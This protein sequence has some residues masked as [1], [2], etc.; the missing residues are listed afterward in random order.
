MAN[1]Q[2]DRGQEVHD[3]LV[4]KFSETRRFGDLPSEQKSASGPGIFS[5]KLGERI[6][7]RDIAL[8]ARQ[9]ALMIDLGITLLRSLDIIESRT[10]NLKLK[11]LIFNL[12]VS[13][14]KGQSF[15]TAL[16]A[17]PSYFNAYFI[18]A[19]RAGEASGDLGTTL[20]QLADYLEKEDALRGKVTKA[21]GFPIM[22]L[23]FAA[24]IVIFLLLFVIPTFANVY[25]EA[26]VTLP[27]LTTLVI[28]VSHILR[29]YWIVLLLVIVGIWLVFRRSG[30]TLGIGP[31]I[32]RMK[33]TIPIV[34]DISMKLSVFRFTR[35]IST[36]LQS[37]VPIVATLRLAAVAAGNTILTRQIESA[38]DEIDSGSTVA[39]SLAHKTIFPA[40]VIDMI[41]IGE[42]VGAVG[43][44]CQKIAGFYERDVDEL[45]ANLATIIEPILTLIMGII[46]LIIALSM[47]LPYFNINQVIFK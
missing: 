36:L 9:L 22:T 10:T 39:D 46:V 16:A 45:V 20:G 19:V 33:L 37:G 28:Q 42:E 34:R 47:F 29:Q 32:D 26:G 38:C 6:T 27:I 3:Q 23:F 11:K 1:R 5:R 17:F 8:F 35:I 4:R 43:P 12:G 30:R 2:S 14:E 41:G 40:M 24:L 21:L 31:W 7:K 13:V 18:T 44:V 15:S 25:K